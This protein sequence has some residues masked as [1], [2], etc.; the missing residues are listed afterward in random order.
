VAN[1]CSRCEESQRA[2]LIHRE[3]LLLSLLV[4]IA[5]LAFFLTRAAAASNR[6]LHRRDAAAWYELGER[7][8]REA[9]V[10]TAIEPLRRAVAKDF[11]SRRYRLALASALAADH[12]DDAARQVLRVLRESAPEHPEANLQLARL[13]VRAGDLREAI[14]YYQNALHGLWG[15]EQGDVRQRVRGELIELLFRHRQDSRALSEVLIL[16]ANVPDDAASQ[17]EVGRLFLRAGDPRR[18]LDHLRRALRGEPNNVRAL[19]GAGEA[20]FALGEYARSR[21]YLQRIADPSDRAREL[22]ALTDLVLANDPLARRLTPDERR[23]RT[24]GNLAHA[25]Q[26]LDACVAQRPAQGARASELSVLQVEARAFGRALTVRKIRAFP[27]TIEAGVEMVARIER[28]LATA[29]DPPALMDR[30]LLLIAE[31]HGFS[32]P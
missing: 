24:V 17:I 12:Q 13:E 29:C 31:R 26:R 7:R 18:A 2:R 28:A 4:G 14:R 5:V 15:N 16:S 21:Q 19:A 25:V 6:E 1:H 22:L 32:E 23:R 3:L 8:L 27:D 20:A 9:D 11:S 10:G 30:A